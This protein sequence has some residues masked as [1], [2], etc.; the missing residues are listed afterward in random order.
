LIELSKCIITC[1]CEIKDILVRSLFLFSQYLCCDFASHFLLSLI[2]Q[3]SEVVVFTEVKGTSSGRVITKSSPF[4]FLLL[5]ISTFLS[6]GFF[7]WFKIVCIAGVIFFY[8]R[9]FSVDFMLVKIQMYN[10]LFFVC[11][12]IKFISYSMDNRYLKGN[13]SDAACFHLWY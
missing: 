7:L 8:F 10:P 3:P 2:L 6:S 13:V 11:H 12:L 4:L 5:M 9:N 1:K